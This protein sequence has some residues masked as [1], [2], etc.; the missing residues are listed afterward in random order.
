MSPSEEENVR[1]FTVG[2]QK[3]MQNR[4]ICGREKERLVKQA[5][6][7][8]EDYFLIIPSTKEVKRR[9]KKWRGEKRA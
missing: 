7:T 3:M 8:Y 4:E 1:F 9:E 5:N 6:M 2:V